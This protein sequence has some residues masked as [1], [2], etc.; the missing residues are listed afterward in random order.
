MIGRYLTL[1]SGRM[2]ALNPLQS[3]APDADTVLMVADR[4]LRPARRPIR[5]GAATLALVAAS[6]AVILVSAAPGAQAAALALR[7][8]GN[9]LVDANGAPVRLLGV[10]RSGT[11]YACSQG[12]GIFDG[13]SDAASITAIA[14]WHTNAVRI[15]LNEDCWLAINGVSA[16][17]GGANYRAPS[18]PTCRPSTP[19]AWPPSSTCTGTLRGR[20][21]RAASR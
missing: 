11:E 10:N 18:A 2:A 9:A 21:S 15:P 16:S 7:V 13:P 6:L 1:R 8:Q 4:V 17:Y 20:R 5:S 14:S 3:E 19:P 12:W